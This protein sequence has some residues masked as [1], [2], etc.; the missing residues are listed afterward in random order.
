MSQFQPSSTLKFMNTHRSMILSVLKDLQTNVLGNRSWKLVDDDFCIGLYNAREFFINVL[1]GDNDSLLVRFITKDTL[2]EKGKNL[3]TKSEV[4]HLIY[5]LFMPGNIDWTGAVTI[6]CY[7][8]TDDLVTALKLHLGHPVS[9]SKT[10]YE[11]DH[12]HE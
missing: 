7:P 6:K 1:P 4:D 9:S 12:A 10:Q 5:T 11:L 2:A 8:N 3:Y